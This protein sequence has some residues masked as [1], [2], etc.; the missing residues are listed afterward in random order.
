MIRRTPRSTRTYTLFPYTTLF[1]SEEEQR[2]LDQH[3]THGQRVIAV[4][5]RVLG[6]QEMCREQQR[7]HQRAE[8][9]GPALLEAENEEFEEPAAR[10]RLDRHRLE[11]R[12]DPVEARM[13]AARLR[14][15]RRPERTATR[16]AAPAPAPGRTEE[17]RVGEASV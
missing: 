16:Q 2:K 7:Q 6:P 4:N 9:A 14:H 10:S 5:W 8:Q 15:G 13:G 3:R 1:R 17:R 12:A 11:P